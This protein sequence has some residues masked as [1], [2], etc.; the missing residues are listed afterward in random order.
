MNYFLSQSDIVPKMMK[1][2][3]NLAILFGIFSSIYGEIV[4]EVNSVAFDPEFGGLHAK[5][6]IFNTYSKK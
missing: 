4:Q 6:V 2:I 5:S 1:L 3:I